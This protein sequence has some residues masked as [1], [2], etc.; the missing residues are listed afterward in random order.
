MRTA[1]SSIRHGGLHTHTHTLGAG[2]PAPPSLAAEPPLE[3]APPEQAPPPGAGSPPPRGQNSWYMLLKILPCPRL[4]L[5]AVEMSPFGKETD[6]NMFNMLENKIIISGGSR[7]FQG[8]P[9][10][11]GR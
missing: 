3:Q 9:T 6:G 2:T 10:P 7:I 8:A 1:R 4:R 11:V 5:R